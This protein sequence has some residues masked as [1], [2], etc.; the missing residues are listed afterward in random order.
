MGFDARG[1][2]AVRRD[3]E[4]LAR[5]S[6]IDLPVSRPTK[7]RTVEQHLLQMCDAFVGRVGG[8]HDE[9]ERAVAFPR[10]FDLDAR[11][12]IV[13]RAV[14]ADCRPATDGM[15]MCV[16]DFGRKPESDAEGAL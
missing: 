15:S 10:H 13:R 4:H 6:E 7:F 1:R 12:R 16:H 2:A 8:Q 14:D 5:H 3:L 9:L 11:E